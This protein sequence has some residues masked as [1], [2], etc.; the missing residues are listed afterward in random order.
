MDQDEGEDLIAE[1]IRQRTRVDQRRVVTRGD[2]RRR[3]YHIIQYDIYVNHTHTPPPP[4][5]YDG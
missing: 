1:D 4:P 3:S 5:V 2:G